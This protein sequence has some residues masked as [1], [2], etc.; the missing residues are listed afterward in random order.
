MTQII[1]I[2]H[3]IQTNIL[4]L[5][6]LRFRFF[7]GLLLTSKRFTLSFNT[8][9]QRFFA[10]FTTNQIRVYCPLVGGELT[11]EGFGE[12]R[13]SKV[14]HPCLGGI[15]PRFNFISKSE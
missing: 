12:Y 13:L 4:T 2:Y 14:V 5:L 3:S 9:K 15:D 11:S 1:I 10:V 8:F 6:P 7:H